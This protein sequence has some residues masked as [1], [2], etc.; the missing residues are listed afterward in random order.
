MIGGIAH[1]INT[2]LAIIQIRT[3]QLIERTEAEE[4][5][6]ESFLKS[7]TSI[8][9]T[10]KRIGSIVNHL[11]SYTRSLT[12]EEILNVPANQLI[13]NTAALTRDRFL[14]EG[15]SL[16]VV[17]CAVEGFIQCRSSDLSQTLLN[18][19][20]DSFFA[21][22]SLNEKWIRVSGSIHEKTVVIEVTDGGL[23]LGLTIA[24]EYAKKYHGTLI[25]DVSSRNTRFIF[26]YPLAEPF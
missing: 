17:P 25:L 7:L 6:K 21:L 18:V 13:E 23:G 12:N 3:D 16:E 5:N 11:G 10:T 20:N 14:S 19:L 9:Q 8:D 22:K 15:I 4:F 24:R 2:P 1:E 26:S